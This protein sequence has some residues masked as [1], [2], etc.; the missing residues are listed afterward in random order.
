MFVILYLVALR[1]VIRLS[2]IALIPL[3]CISVSVVPCS[4]RAAEMCDYEL[5]G[6]EERALDLCCCAGESH[7]TFL[8]LAKG[9]SR[10]E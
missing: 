9:Q 3:T 7:D 4:A 8:R 5:V 6:G 2:S 10:R 1:N